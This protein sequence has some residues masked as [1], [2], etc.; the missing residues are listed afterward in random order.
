MCVNCNHSK[1]NHTIK[2][3]NEWMATWC[4]NCD[5]CKTQLTPSQKI[6]IERND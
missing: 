2:P 1:E 4:G 6:M 3:T 5:I